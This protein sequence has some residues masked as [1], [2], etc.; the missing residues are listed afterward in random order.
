MYPVCFVNY[1]TSLYPH[2]SLSRTG[3]GLHNIPS[4]AESPPLEDGREHKG[5]G[6][7]KKDGKLGKRK[8]RTS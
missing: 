8:E 1:V 6:S 5:G 4:P 3:R 2:P 7:E